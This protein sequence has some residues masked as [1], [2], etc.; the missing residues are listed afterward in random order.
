MLNDIYAVK[1]EIFE[2]PMD[3]LV[4]LIRKNEV[5]IYDIPISMITEQYLAYIELM[6]MM[7]INLAADF[8]HLA[9]TLAQIKSRMLLPSHGIESDEEED[10]R[11][12]IARPL[13]EYL[14]MKNAADELFKR[15]LLDQDIFTR[16]PD[17]EDIP[18]VEEDGTIEIGIFELIKAF[19]TVLA[20]MK[21]EH[22]V[23]LESEKISI[24]DRMME[25]IGIL[26]EKNSLVFD[27]LFDGD[28]F[29]RDIIVTFLAI[30]EMAKMSLI[31]IIQHIQS[32]VIRLFYV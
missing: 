2:G 8:I 30:L 22:K 10:P 12:A 20:N 31:K 4:Y 5:D 6:K 7:N 28:R 13:I 1:L 32:G 25:L 15:E 18:Q 17:K 23:D 14:Q 9:A 21:K 3:L 24:K 26:E 29:K 19:N 16:T 11:L 27:E